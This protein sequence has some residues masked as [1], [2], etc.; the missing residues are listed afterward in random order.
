MAL[1]KSLHRMCTSPGHPLGLAHTA[2]V[3]PA[4][5]GRTARWM[6]RSWRCACTTPTVMLPPAPNTIA[7][8]AHAV[9]A[10]FCTHPRAPQAGTAACNPAAPWSCPNAPRNLQ[11]PVHLQSRAPTPSPWR[12]GPACLHCI[13]P[14][15]AC[16]WLNTLLVWRR[17]CRLACIVRAPIQV[18]V[19]WRWP[20]Q[21]R[22]C[23]GTCG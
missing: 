20:H 4:S 10:A 19:G 15:L 3:E 11:A 6:A 1:S 18:Q 22:S 14:I 7:T 12:P 16:R 13:D 17:R 23:A 2:N 5:P 21:Q 9:A 8:L